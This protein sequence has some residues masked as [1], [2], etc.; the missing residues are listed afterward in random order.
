MGSN[1]AEEMVNDED[2]VVDFGRAD[3]FVKEYQT[4]EIF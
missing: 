2:F 3:S 4:E 1:D